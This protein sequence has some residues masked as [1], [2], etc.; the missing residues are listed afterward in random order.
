MQANQ[1]AQSIAYSLDDGMTWTTYDEVNPVILEPPT[2]YADQ[3]LEFRDP[4]VFWHE[5]SGKWIALVSLAKLHK[6]VIYTS[7]DLKEWEQTSEFGPANAVGGVWEC[8]SLFPLTVDGGEET[9]WVLQLGLNPGGPPGTPGSGTQYIVGE[10][11]G[12]EFMP[13][14]ESVQ[15]T[16][17]VD[18]GPDFYAALIFG[19]MPATDRVDIAWMNNWKYGEAIPTDPWRSAASIPRRLSLGTSANGTTTLIQEPI[20]EQ[21]LSQAQRQQWDSVPDGT[22]KLNMT[23]KALDMTL[24]FSESKATDF[25]LIV[26]AASDLSEQTRVGY[27]LT[28]EQLFINR[29]TSGEAGFDGEFAATYY[30]PMSLLDGNITMRVLVDWS[31]VEVFGGAGEVSLTAQIF[32][33]DDSADTYLFSTGGETSDVKFSGSQVQSGWGTT[34]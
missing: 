14:P 1:Q 25:G 7:D 27:D 16:N 9:K 11:D 12:T 15:Q 22:T 32:P 34:E 26:R 23:G 24:S 10:F 21:G 28:T 29:T 13:D 2:E 5:D 30:A 33:S 8:P 20:L 17:W 6:L 19:G 18:W 31:S 3:I 4:G